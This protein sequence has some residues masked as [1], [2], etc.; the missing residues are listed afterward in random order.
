M[1]I[2]QY[3]FATTI[4]GQNNPRLN[5]YFVELFCILRHVLFIVHSTYLTDE[6][7]F[8][9]HYTAVV[10]LHDGDKKYNWHTI[11]RR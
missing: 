9:H 1:T 7:R 6:R 3:P 2:S 5:A 4:V 11:R 8:L 10:E